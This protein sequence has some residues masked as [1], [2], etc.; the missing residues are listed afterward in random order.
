MQNTRWRFGLLA[1][2]MIAGLALS[3]PAHAQQAAPASPQ[4]AE[5]AESE[6]IVVTGSRIARRDYTSTSPIATID[7][8]QLQ[9]S[10]E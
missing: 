3:M 7:S 1:S 8:A 6:D 5:A 2:T 10:G 9:S 4:D